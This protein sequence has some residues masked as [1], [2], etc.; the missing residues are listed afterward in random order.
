MSEER[1]FTPEEIKQEQN[2]EAEDTP[3]KRSNF[4]VVFFGTSNHRSF[5]DK[6]AIE[7]ATELARD[8]VA[9]GGHKIVTGG[10][11]AGVMGAASKAAAEQAKKL[12]RNDLIPEGITIGKFL[13]EYAK[14]SEIKEADGVLERIR[15]LV[16]KSNALVVLH[17]KTGTVVELLNSISSTAL[18]Q[19][20]NKEDF[21]PKP[22]IIVDPSL[23][24]TDLLS[25]LK[26]RDPKLERSIG[27][28]FVVSSS[29][30]QELEKI[31]QQ[32]SS[33]IEIYYKESLGAQ[34]TEDERKLLENF[35][36]KKFF[37]RQDTFSE[38]SGI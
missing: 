35:S 21:I 30:G 32:I 31:I 16:E 29:E 18:E 37:E 12:G 36:L 5:D 20:K 9:N 28:I 22:V 3:E 17:G 34:E 26:R 25:F 14:D 4:K 6:R 24:H 15:I 13:G 2:V 10:Y 33:L 38:G 23:E 8:Q 11:E 7:I 1:G 19:A 27:N